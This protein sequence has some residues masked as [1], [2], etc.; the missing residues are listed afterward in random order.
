MDPCQ[1]LY[2]KK[3]ICKHKQ[4]KSNYVGIHGS[5]FPFIYSA[6]VISLMFNGINK[7]DANF[8]KPST[9]HLFENLSGYE[10]T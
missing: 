10:Y 4:P 8:L 1:L 2:K 6:F 5:V 3:N 7:T 9:Q